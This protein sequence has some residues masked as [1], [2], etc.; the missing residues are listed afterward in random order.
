MVSVEKEQDE[1]DSEY[2]DAVDS[3]ELLPTPESKFFSQN[4]FKLSS[5]N[6]RTSFILAFANFGDRRRREKSRKLKLI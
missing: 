2:F 3:E 4:S 6:R 5:R 1:S